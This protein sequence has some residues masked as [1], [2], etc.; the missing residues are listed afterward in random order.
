MEATVPAVSRRGGFS[1]LEG[2]FASAILALTI[3]GMFGL[4]SGMF[5]RAGQARG[6]AEATEIARAEVERAKLFGM[7]YLPLGTYNATTGNATW[8]G[9]YSPSSNSWVSGGSSFYDVSGN[10]VASK[11]ATGA[12]YEVQLQIT[13]TS[14]LPKTGG[15]TLQLESRRTLVVTVDTVSDNAEVLRMATLIAPGGL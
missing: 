7:D 11:T 13:D 8:L 1:T 6:A 12:T 2:L 4:W 9:A 3:T 14:V 15:Y 10:R 5:R